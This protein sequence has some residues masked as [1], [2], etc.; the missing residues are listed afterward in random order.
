MSISRR[1]GELI[2][3]AVYTLA[4]YVLVAPAFTV[5]QFD[6]PQWLSFL[7]VSVLFGGGTW[8]L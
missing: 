7:I 4:T 2:P 8:G 3:F 5:T 6:L 1:L